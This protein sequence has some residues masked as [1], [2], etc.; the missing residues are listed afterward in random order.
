MSAQWP[1]SIERS[2]RKRDTHMDEEIRE[3]AYKEEELD[4]IDQETENK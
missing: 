3:K 4:K 1:G 2:E